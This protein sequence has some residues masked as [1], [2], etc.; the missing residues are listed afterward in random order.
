ML[1]VALAALYLLPFVWMITTS[2]K[3]GP[4]SIA[5]PPVWIPSPIVF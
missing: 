5:T 4:Q 1:L 2:L 3:T